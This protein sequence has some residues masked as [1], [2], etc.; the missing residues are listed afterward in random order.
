MFLNLRVVLWFLEALC[1]WG[2]GASLHG[3]EKGARFPALPPLL[4]VSVRL[5]HSGS[6]SPCAPGAPVHVPLARE[7]RAA[8]S[9]EVQLPR[10]APPRFAVAS[11]C[12][13]SPLPT[14]PSDADFL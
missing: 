10:A 12:K 4:V 8:D 13:A 9:P 1:Y 11:R 3:P 7:T 2:K 14:L 5:S 6:L